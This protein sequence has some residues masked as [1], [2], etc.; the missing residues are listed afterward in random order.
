VLISIKEI[1]EGEEIQISYI[2]NGN[3]KQERSE[4]LSKMYNF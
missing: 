2:D 3:S 1:K 4:Q